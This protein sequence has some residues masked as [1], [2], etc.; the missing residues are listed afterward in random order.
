[1]KKIFYE[2]AFGIL[3]IVSVVLAIID[4]HSGLTTLQSNIDII[5]WLIFVVDYTVRFILAKDRKYFIKENIFDLIAILP[6]SSAMRIFRSFKMLKLLK[7]VKMLKV[8]RFTAVLGRAYKNFSA[9]FNTNG[10]KYVLFF[11]IFIVLT[12]GTLISYV[13][14]RSFSDGI[15]WAFVTTTTVGYGDIS[16]ATD[17][18]RIIACVLMLVGIGLIGSLT[19]T[20]TSFF[21]NKPTNQVASN[22]RVDMVLKM[23]NELND[24]E[25][26]LFDKLK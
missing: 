7:I 4:M 22:D 8:L 25:K 5:I 21:M 26:N 11:S 15:W 13:E 18:G 14:N 24:D 12:G 1:M 2:I 19:S 9:F 20:I 10:F 3:A 16:P 6:F 17:I 23:Y